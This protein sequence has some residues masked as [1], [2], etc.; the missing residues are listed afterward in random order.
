V[1]KA[2]KFRIYPNKEQAT[3]IQKTFGCTRYV[4][5]YYLAKRKDAYEERK[6]TLSYIACSADMT[7][8]KKQTEWLKE[9]DATALQSSIRD[10]DEG[11]QNFFRRVKNGEKPGY[12]HFK[13][14]KDNKKSF[15]SKCVGTNIK[16]LGKQIQLPKLGFV[17]CRVSKQVEGR[18]LSA[19]VSQNPSGKYFVSV[20][21]TDVEWQPLDPTGAIVG[22]DLGLKELAITSDGQHFQNP[23]YLIKSQKKLVK[24]QRQLSRKSKGSMNREKARIKV[25]RLHEHISN[26]RTDSIHKMTTSI[27]RDYDLIA[28][29]TLMPKNMM[30][31]RKLAKAISDAAWGEVARQLEYK[32]KWYGKCLV[33]VDRFFPSSQTCN[34]CGFKNVATKDLAI[35]EWDCPQ[36]G[37]HNDRDVN[38]S[39]NILDEGV[40]IVSAA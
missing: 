29:E 32:S 20:L 33:K 14:K 27:A 26:Q 12:P 1:E 16:V 2:Y 7:T 17:D 25:A 22:I 36:C 37:K 18:I 31:N 11:Y 28:M 8:L 40:R 24:L 4:Y 15:K 21:C 13:S 9:V 5:N 19:T 30:K 38:A 35:R 6:E 39:K 23:K 3:L 34:H 10:L